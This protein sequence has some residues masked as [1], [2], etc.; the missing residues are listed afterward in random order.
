MGSDF[1]DL[2]LLTIMTAYLFLYYGHTSVGIFAF[3]Q[4]LLIDIFSGGLHGLFAFLYLCVLGA[5]YLGCPFLDLHAPKGQ[6]IIIA[7]AVLFKKIIF[8]MVLI[9]FSPDVVFLKSFLWIS[10]ASVI[11]TGLISPVLFH[12]FNRLRGISTKDAGVNPVGE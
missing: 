7:S 4:G 9:A 12:I 11:G 1:L 3:G 8:L 5:I 10:G 6:V 2:D